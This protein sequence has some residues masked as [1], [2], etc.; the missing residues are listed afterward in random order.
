MKPKTKTLLFVL[1][2]FVLGGAGGYVG[3]ESGMLRPTRPARM[4]PQEFR[5]DFHRKLNLDSLQIREIDSLL[6]VY[7]ER[8]SVY[9][10]AMMRDRDTLRV[11]L[12]RRLTAPQQQTY[13][14]MN[15]QMDARYERGRRDTVRNGH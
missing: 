5:K 12:R 15:R 6:D 11:E 10:D 4:S 1:L 9:R 7:W 13:D 2:S 3:F 8:M 14:A